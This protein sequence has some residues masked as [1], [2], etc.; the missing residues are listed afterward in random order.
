MS[1]SVGRSARGARPY[2]RPPGVRQR[3]HPGGCPGGR[4]S[5]IGDGQYQRGELRHRRLRR[6]PQHPGS[7]RLTARLVELLHDWNH[8]RPARP[9]ITVYRA[10]TPDDQLGPGVRIERSD[11]RLTITW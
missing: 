10:G 8:T 2:R 3:H 4:I 11:T 7:R 9:I 5:R 1:R 6:P